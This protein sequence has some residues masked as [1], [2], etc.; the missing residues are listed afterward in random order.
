MRKRVVILGGGPCGLSAAWRLTTG[1]ED[2]DVVVVEREEEVGGLC[3]T[4]AHGDF[5]FDLGGH[6]FISSDPVLI[7]RIRRLMGEELL[8]RERKSVIRLEGRDFAYP[9]SASDLL[10]RLPPGL[11]LRAFADFLRTGSWRRNGGPP[12]VSFE[13]WVVRRFG[14]TLFDLFFGPYSEKLWGRPP[15]RLSADWA[16][17]R[18]SLL[19]LGEVALRLLGLGQ[20]TPR[21]YSKRYYYPREGI[22]QIFRFI[23]AEVEAGGGLILRGT[24]AMSVRSEGGRVVSVE[25]DRSDG[26]FF[27]YCDYLISTLPLPELIRLFRD[28]EAHGVRESATRLQFRSMR[29]LNLLIDRPQI[30][31]NTWIYVPESRYLMTRIQEPKRRSPHS[32]PPGKTSLMLEIPCAQG[33]GLWTASDDALADRCLR[34]LDALGI[35]IRNDVLGCFS[36]RAVHAYPIYSLD[37]RIH[38]GRLLQFLGRFENLLSCGR[39]GTFR[40]LFMDAA[41]KMGFSAARCVLGEADCEELDGIAAE[42]RLIEAGATT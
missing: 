25:I 14:R 2:I 37:Y 24:R 33:D 20:G 17:Q 32:A 13:D 31:P 18:I 3:R 42:A 4:L 19:N 7:E 16:A 39:Q 22:G 29:F 9:L 15:S 5:R 36:T 21:T 28:K 38:R 27:L 30:S 10:K 1:A 41:M 12:D 35:R 8:L 34:D 26:R 6:R 23:A 11:T 40:Y